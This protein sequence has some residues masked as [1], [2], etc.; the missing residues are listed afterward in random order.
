MLY[1]DAYPNITEYPLDDRD[2]LIL[3][4][5]SSLSQIKIPVLSGLGLPIEDVNWW[6][7][8]NLN[9][10]WSNVHADSDTIFLGRI[11]DW[12]CYLYEPIR[13]DPKLFSKIITNGITQHFSLKDVVYLLF[14]HSNEFADFV[15]EIRER[16]YP[17]NYIKK[18]IDQYHDLNR[19]YPCITF[20]EL[21][22]LDP[23]TVVNDVGEL[24]TICDTVI[25]DNAKSVE[26]YRKGKVNS[27]NHLKGQV[28]K[29][30][31]GKADVK[32]VTE[33]LERKL[34]YD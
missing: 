9:I 15:K 26:D 18:I 27:I 12:M 3:L 10:R 28:M 25:K 34:K 20:C 13:Q 24:E 2:K 14:F 33:I 7:Y 19:Y 16:N 6:L 8:T 17:W 4:V 23:Y 11:L 32:M 22:S 5:D 29:L 30:T 1:G 31:K 21:T